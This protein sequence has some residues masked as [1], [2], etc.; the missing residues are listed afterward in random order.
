M[1]SHNKKIFTVCDQFRD[2]SVEVKFTIDSLTYSVFDEVMMVFQSLLHFPILSNL[3]LLGLTHTH[4][5]I[6]LMV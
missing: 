6:R 2:Q 3:L 5:H 1:S 4:T